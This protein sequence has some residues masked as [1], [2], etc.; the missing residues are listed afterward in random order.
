M[1]YS[2]YDEDDYREYGR[3]GM[4]GTGPY[5]RYNGGRG[6]GRYRG[7]DNMEEMREYYMNYNEGRQQYNRGNYNGGEQEM[8]EATE[9]IM[10]NITEIVKELSESQ[11]PEVMQIIKR[12]AKEIME[13]R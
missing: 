7:H 11:N 10:D 5:S 2:G 6:S 3:R 8:I 12:S 1:R 13:M 9:G 4:R